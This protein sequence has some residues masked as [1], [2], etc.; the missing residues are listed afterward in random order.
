MTFSYPAGQVGGQLTAAVVSKTGKLFSNISAI[1]SQIPLKDDKT[2]VT[3]IDVRLRVS[4]SVPTILAVISNSC[5]TARRYPS[6]VF[7]AFKDRLAPAGEQGGVWDD[8]GRAGL[9]LDWHLAIDE[10]QTRLAQRKGLPTDAGDSQWLWESN[11]LSPCFSALSQ[12][13]K[14]ASPTSCYPTCN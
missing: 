12:G 4:D 13:R 1:I 3:C 5:I 8:P 9:H 6:C 2:V 7:S 14:A 10:R 11:W